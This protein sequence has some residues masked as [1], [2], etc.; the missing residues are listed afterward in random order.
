MAT[1]RQAFAGGSSAETITAILRDRPVPP[2]QLN[3]QLSSKLEETIN[4]AL[5]KDRDMRY[6]HAADIL[7][8]VKRLKRD[9]DSGRSVA[10]SAAVAGASR[11][12][13]EEEHRQDARAT[14]SGTPALRRWPL[15][16]AGLLTLIAASGLV[17]FLT[18]RAPP[19][20]P[21]TEL[22]QK[23]LTFNS[24]EN[25]VQSGAISPDGKYLAYS[26][27]GGIHVKLL[28]TGEEGSSQGRPEF[29]PAPGMS[30]RGFPTA[31]NCSPTPTKP[32]ATGACGRSRCWGNL[33]ES[34]ARVRWGL[35]LARWDAH[36]LWPSR[37]FGIR[38]RNLGDGQPRR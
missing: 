14:A 38:S 17:W 25:A 18:H 27:P 19:P 31:H 26:D 4:K 10:V 20:K 12:H 16:L 34:F 5:E 32:A 11:S 9:T 30:H 1:G 7:T 28:S 3:P 15:A 36:C 33:H 8:D 29:P 23:R 21:S 2:S 22:T 37:S 6:Q 13:I 35:S 24:S